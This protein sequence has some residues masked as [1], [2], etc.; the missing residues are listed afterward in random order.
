MTDTKSL[1]EQA[2]ESMFRERSK[3]LI[4]IEKK[5]KLPNG[6]VLGLR[7]EV[8]DWAFVIKLAVLVEATVVTVLLTHLN[9]EKL[10]GHLSKLGNEQRLH[11][12]VTLGVLEKEDALILGRLATIRNSFA[13]RVENLTG[14]L[15]TYVSSLNRDQKVEALQNLFRLPNGKKVG[16]TVNV[17][18]LLNGFRDV[19]LDAVML[20]LISLSNHDDSVSKEHQRR[21]WHAQLADKP[22][23]VKTATAAEEQ[24]VGIGS[25]RTPTPH[26]GIDISGAKE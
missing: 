19:L 17:D 12:A 26:S 11:L 25:V 7:S 6:F 5:L 16:N 15:Q 21:A 23:S 13:H 22:L 24:T 10:R 20:P 2:K 14:S 1:M 4:P 8:D 9:N 18:F 3:M